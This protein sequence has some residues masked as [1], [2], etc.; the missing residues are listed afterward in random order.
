[1][2]FTILMD[3]SKYL[4]ITSNA[5]LYQ[6]ENY[7]D[8]IQFV[9][10]AIYNDNDL[11]DYTIAMEYVDSNN[12]SYLDILE[13]DEEL[14]K[15]KYIRCTLPITTKLSKTAGQV[16]IQLTMNKVDKEKYVQYTLHTS[17]ITLEIHPVSDYYKFADESLMKIDA[18]IGKLDAKIGYLADNAAI[19]STKVPDDLGIDTDGTLKLSI[20]EELIGNGVNVGVVEVPDNNDNVDDGIIDITGLYSQVE[21]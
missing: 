1:M 21:L 5:V 11:T 3:D 8:N 12:N 10:P 2:G 20:K 16:K 6:G 7:C 4:K 18:L 9:I 19:L 17:E 13:Q 15:E 14:Y